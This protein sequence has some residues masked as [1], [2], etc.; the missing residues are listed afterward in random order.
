MMNN[1]FQWGRPVQLLNQ[2]CG[3]DFFQKLSNFD[4]FCCCGD[5][6][7]RFVIISNENKLTSV[8]TGGWM[9]RRRSA[10]NVGF[11]HYRGGGRSARQ[12]RPAAKVLL[13]AD[14][15]LLV[16]IALLIRPERRRSLA[17]VEPVF[18]R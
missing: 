4:S 2:H 16:E 11:S 12:R 15:K 8:C 7:K 1:L 18:W 5:V 14:G 13:S 9:I 10:V 17:A 6:G 3:R